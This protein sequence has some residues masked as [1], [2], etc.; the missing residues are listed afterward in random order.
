MK[1]PVGAD[2]D[3]TTSDD[4]AFGAQQ[5]GLFALVAGNQPATDVDDPPPRDIERGRRQ[6]PTDESRPFRVAGHLRDV[7]VC[8]DLAGPESHDH[9]DDSSFTVVHET[10]LAAS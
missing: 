8:G 4:N 5:L 7:A 1:R 6:D 2:R 3:P 9:V 10:I